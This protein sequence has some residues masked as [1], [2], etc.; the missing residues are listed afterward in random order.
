[1]TRQ[2]ELAELLLEKFEPTFGF[3]D[4]TDTSDLLKLPDCAEKTELLSLMNYQDATATLTRT[5]CFAYLRYHKKWFKQSRKI[6]LAKASLATLRSE[7]LLAFGDG[8]PD[9]TV[10]VDY[11]GI[12]QVLQTLKQQDLLPTGF[13]RIKLN[14]PAWQMYQYMG[15]IYGKDWV[16][17]YKQISNSLREYLYSVALAKAK[18]RESAFVPANT[19]PVADSSETLLDT[20]TD[21]VTDTSDNE[22]PADYYNRKVTQTRQTGKLVRLNNGSYLHC[23]NGTLLT[24]SKLDPREF[25]ADQVESVKSNGL[26]VVSS[27]NQTAD[28]VHTLTEAKCLAQNWQQ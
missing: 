23:V 25:E 15:D 22:S 12:Q 1:M 28:P 24:I 8:L 9:I 19:D 26:W 5:Q 7:V 11:R 3:F 27:F 4:P 18:L 21:P 14:S 2:L 10:D 13:K 6:N 17:Q 20:Q 16:S